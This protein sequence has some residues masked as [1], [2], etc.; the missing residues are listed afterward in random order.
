MTVVTLSR[1]V[2]L[3]RDDGVPWAR[4]RIEEAPAA[5]GPWTALETQTLSPVDTDPSQPAARSLTTTLGT[6]K[7]GWYRLVWIDGH[8]AESAATPP[9]QNTSDL[10]VGTRPTVAEVA[11]RLR[12]RTKAS[13]TGPG[14]SGGGRELGTFTSQTRPTAG[15]V[16]DLIDDAL[17]EVL[18]KVQTPTPGSDYETRVRRTVALYTAILIELS[19]FPEQVKANHSP[20]AIYQQL[21][22]SRIKAL[23]AEGETGK[24]QGEGS[25][26]GGGD[27]PGDAAW[28]FPADTG[29]LVGWAKSLVGP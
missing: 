25:G 14:G 3:E 15:D 24:P 18:G 17:D 1:Y 29:G 27:S 19:Y 2:P 8:N 12:A 26:T 16:E 22:T 5:T 23:I 9:L 13:G 6:L 21:Y 28:V 4:V 7:E 20:V 10:A 11:A